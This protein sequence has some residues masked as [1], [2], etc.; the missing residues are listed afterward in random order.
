MRSSSISL[1]DIR[2]KNGPITEPYGTSLI[3]SRQL[4]DLPFMTTHFFFSESE[5]SN[6]IRIYKKQIRQIK[7]LFTKAMLSIVLQI[8]SFRKLTSLSCII[9]SIKFTVAHVRLID[10]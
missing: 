1:T 4:D 3:K 5:S 8:F 7:A 2:K 6:N 9:V 10:L